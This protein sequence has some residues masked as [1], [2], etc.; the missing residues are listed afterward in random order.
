MRFSRL[1]NV[2]LVLA[3]VIM[4]AL[5]ASPTRAAQYYWN[6]LSIDQTQATCGPN[7]NLYLWSDT[8]WPTG[9]YTNYYWLTNLRTGTQTYSTDTNL[10]NFP[11]FQGLVSWRLGA[12][13]SAD[14]NATDQF[15][16]HF[17]KYTSNVLVWD[18]EA[19]IDCGTGNVTLLPLPVEACAIS[20]DRINSASCAGPVALYCTDNGLEVWDIDADGVGTLAFTYNGSFDVPASNTLLQQVGDIQL[21]V[22]DSGEFQVN[23]DAGE[24]KTYAFVFNGCPYDG[25]GYNANIDPNE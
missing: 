18:V 4:A 22:L 24:G 8:S 13:T 15:L 12:P 5:A 16:I 1:R 17:V 20:D 6:P 11:A 3:F 23:A 2:I 9:P 19:I 10:N 25:G 14:S 7:V 21:W